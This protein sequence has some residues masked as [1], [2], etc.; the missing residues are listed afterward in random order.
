MVIYNLDLITM[1][2]YSLLMSK[3][4]QRKRYVPNIYLH[5]VC[6]LINPHAC[7][8]ILMH[9]QVVVVI[10]IIYLFDEIIITLIS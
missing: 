3:R 1:E 10:I 8:I 9:A 5:R 4:I 6:A 7:F 2:S